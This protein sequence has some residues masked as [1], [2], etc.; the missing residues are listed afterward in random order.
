MS[1]PAKPFEPVLGVAIEGIVIRWCHE[2]N[3]H[4]D[5]TSIEHFR[6]ALRVD[7]QLH[8]SM[9]PNVGDEISIDDIAEYRFCDR[10]REPRDARVAGFS[11]ALRA[12]K[13]RKVMADLVAY[14]S[15]SKLVVFI[16]EYRRT[17]VLL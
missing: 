14:S 17:D 12:K 6:G 13:L 10:K 8:F 5:V 1:D 15:Q 3:T 7:L 16:D 4:I 9:I 2:N 11:K